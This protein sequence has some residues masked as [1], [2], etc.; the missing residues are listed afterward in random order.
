MCFSPIYVSSFQDWQPTPKIS[1][2]ATM[3]PDTIT[4]A[5][6]A[7]QVLFLPINGQPSDADLV[8]LFNPISPILLKSTYDRVNSVH[9]LWG[10]IANADRYLHHYGAPFVLPATCPACYDPAINAE[11]SRV[12]CIHAKTAWATKI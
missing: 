2:P 11:A 3:T 4:S 8:H 5:L 1:H 9:S 12:N 10:F 6:A 7:A